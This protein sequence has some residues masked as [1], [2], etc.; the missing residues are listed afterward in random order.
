MKITAAER[1]RRSRAAI[2]A[3]KAGRARVAARR[4]P[5]TYF[6]HDWLGSDKGGTD[7]TEKEAP[8]KGL[9][10]EISEK[11]E[12]EKGKEGQETEG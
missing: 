2:E 1:A 9:E 4:R 11:E 6:L 3:N 10:R 5:K 7:E 8:A 12:G